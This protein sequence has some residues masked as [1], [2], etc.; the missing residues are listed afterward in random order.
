MSETL[1][2]IKE[3]RSIRVFKDEQIKDEELQAVL[4]A[5]LYAPSAMNEQS[6]HFT[7]IQNAELLEKFTQI[8]K[9]TFAK[10]DIDQLKSM[11]NN[12]KYKAFYNAP[13]AIIISGNVKAT[14]TEADTAAATENILLA[15]KAIGLGACWIGSMPFIFGNGNNDDFKKELGIPEDYNPINSIALGY[16]AAENSKA[17]ARKEHKVNIIK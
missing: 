2:V 12:D 3:R 5:G 13:T 8:A 1:E 14:N 11:A 4:E 16:A 17:P 7:V 6:W 10:S 9:N 15:A